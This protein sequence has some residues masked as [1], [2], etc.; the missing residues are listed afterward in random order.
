MGFTLVAPSVILLIH[1]QHHTS[2]SSVFVGLE[3]R[4]TQVDLT[5]NEA[6]VVRIKE[7][8]S[9]I[10]C[11]ISY[12]SLYYHRYFEIK[13]YLNNHKHNSTTAWAVEDFWLCLAG[14]LFSSVFV[15]PVLHLAIVLGP[16]PHPQS[17]EPKPDWSRTLLLHH[18]GTV[19]IRNSMYAQQ[20]G[21][22][23]LH[24]IFDSKIDKEEDFS[25]L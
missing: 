11:F 17:L 6:V 14:R 9:L 20:K 15:V 23:G 7:F 8:W 22:K 1:K 4:L 21:C 2:Q 25:F 12:I 10:N 19:S 5:K 24:F 3:T 13:T 18:L 16:N